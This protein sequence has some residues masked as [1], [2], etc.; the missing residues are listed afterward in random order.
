MHYSELVSSIISNNCVLFAG[1]GLTCNSGGRL[2]N[3]LIDDLVKHFRYEGP[4]TV[5]KFDIVEYIM[6][7]ND[8]EIVYKYIQKQLCGAYIDEALIDFIKLPWFS[9]ITTNYDIA[10]ENA[11]NE[12][13]AKKICTVDENYNFILEWFNSELYCVKLMGSCDKSYRDKGSMVLNTGELEAANDERKRIFQTLEAFAVNRSILFVGYSFNDGI[14]LDNLKKIKAIMGKPKNKYY[15][16]FLSEKELDAN[17]RYQLEKYNVEPIFG[18]IKEFA[19]ILAEEVSLCDMDDQRNKKILYGSQIVSLDSGHVGHFLSQFDPIFLEDLNEEIKIRNFLKGQ[20][21]SFRPFENGWHFERKEMNELVEAVLDHTNLQESN[22]VGVL[23]HPGSGKSFTIHAA[24]DKLIREHN[25]IAIKIRNSINKIPRTEDM[26]EFVTELERSVKE[27]KLPSFERIILFS[28]VDLEI[29]DYL[30]Y[31]DLSKSSRYPIDLLFESLNFPEMRYL[32]KTDCKFLIVDLNAKLTQEETDRLTNY[33]LETNEKYKLTEI[34]KQ[35]SIDLVKSEKS[36][37]SLMYRFLDPARHSIEVIISETFEEIRKYDPKTKDLVCFIC[38]SSYFKLPMPISILRNCFVTKY[39]KFDLDDLDDLIEKASQLVISSTYPFPAA[40]IYHQYIA[41]YLV[42]IIKIPEMDKYLKTLA[43]SVHLT[44]KIDANFV[45]S[46]FIE[47]GV[48]QG[49]YNPK[50]FSDEG[51]IDA[52]VSLKNRQPARLIIHQLAKLC[53]RKNCKSEIVKELLDEALYQQPREL[54]LYE[55]I[56]NIFTTKANIE[57]NTNKQKFLERGYEDSEVQDIIRLL[58]KAKRSQS[59]NIHP[60]DVHAR[61]LTEFWKNA[62]EEENKIE[63]ISK[64]VDVITEGLD[65]CKEPEIEM[66]LNQLLFDCYKE[67]D[68]EF[69]EEKAEAMLNEKSNGVGYY[70]LAKYYHHNGEISKAEEFI[71]ICLEANL[72]P[73]NAIFLKLEILFSKENP[74]YKM[75]LSYADLIAKSTEISVTWKVAYLLGVTYATNEL[76]YPAKRFFEEAWRKSK[77]IS[78]PLHEGYHFWMDGGRRRRFTGNI[79]RM[80][81]STGWISTHSVDGWK[82]DI[83]F[84]PEK[85]KNYRNLHIGNKV[86]FEVGYNLKGPIAFE[87]EPYQW[88]KKD[89]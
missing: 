30:R 11:L 27:K 83:Y 24:V 71:D 51:L 73:S 60:Y 28:T 52:L 66:E 10:L 41:E 15:A 40:S 64:T 19:N 22:F 25:S 45:S 56:E 20:L 46:L 86:M 59:P 54:L 53:H 2:W 4:V 36:F 3:D 33:L 31:I 76:F 79:S 80:T 16:L 74:N 44:S 17:K 84:Q 38:L 49:E 23:G 72:K 75:L 32:Q 47:F 1:A 85:Q 65:I 82:E 5:D 9:V 37:L 8:P 43:D 70:A 21:Y 68:V 50:P 14:F 62:E 88:R 67:L 57:W 29:G 12:H 26:E 42:N 81:R 77:E 34:D 89:C 55:R 78:N 39:R 18:D 87:I 48:R 69:T 63:L 6:D 13:H 58:D 7:E 35:T 61:I